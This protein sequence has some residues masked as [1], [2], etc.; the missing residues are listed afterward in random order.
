[1]RALPEPASQRVRVMYDG[2][3]RFG[4]GQLSV[5]LLLASMALAVVAYFVGEGIGGPS[6]G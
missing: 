6:H 3:T 5:V 1:V 4:G 2:R